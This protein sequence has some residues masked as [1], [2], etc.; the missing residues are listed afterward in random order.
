MGSTWCL[1]LQSAVLRFCAEHRGGGRERIDPSSSQ[2]NLRWTWF[3]CREVHHC[4]KSISHKRALLHSCTTLARIR[5]HLV[6]FQ[7]GAPDQ[8]AGP[9]HS[10]QLSC[11]TQ[12]RAAT[13]TPKAMQVISELARRASKP[14]APLSGKGKAVVPR[15]SPDRVVYLS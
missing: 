14:M 3:T 6:P 9:T 13:D 5:I 1:I 7:C 12:Y 8:N 4:C 10:I 2:D 15:H 11:C